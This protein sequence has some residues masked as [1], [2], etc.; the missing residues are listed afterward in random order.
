MDFGDS[1][2][3]LLLMKNKIRQF[4]A[5]IAQLKRLETLNLNQNLVSKMP[6]GV[7]ELPRLKG[8]YL[9]HNRIRKITESFGLGSLQSTLAKLWLYGNNVVELPYSFRFLTTLDDLRLEHNPMRSPPPALA[10]EG[11][12]RIRIYLEDRITRNTALKEQLNEKLLR[13]N[14]RNLSPQSSEV[15]IRSKYLAADT[16][17]GYLND[18]DLLYVDKMVDN[19]INADYYNYELTLQEIVAWIEET[20]EHRRIE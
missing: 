20:K 18:D 3:M 6:K 7:H 15:L 9:S 4:P 2:T 16:T 5:N 1:L 12:A 19:Y 14:T 8:L 11:P 10:L 17:V 13:F